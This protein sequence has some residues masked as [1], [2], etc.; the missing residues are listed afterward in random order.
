VVWEGPGQ[1]WPLPDFI[2]LGLVGLS[3][4]VAIQRRVAQPLLP[5]RVVLDR[6]RGGAYIALAVNSAGLLAVFLFLTYYLQQN[7]GL[8]PVMTGLAFLPAPVATAL[9]ATQPRPAWPSASAPTASSPPASRS[10][11]S[12]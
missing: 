6:T 7:L 2:A 9:G 3:A 4:F 10:L 1:A 11:P 12:G 8:S 5:L